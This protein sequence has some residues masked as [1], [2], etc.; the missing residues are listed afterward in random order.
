MVDPKFLGRYV[1]GI[2]CDGASYHSSKSARDRDILRQKV[3]EELG[4]TIYRIWSTDW[5]RDPAGQSRKLISFIQ[6][7]RERTCAPLIPRGRH[8]ESSMGLAT[9]RT[10]ISD[11][12]WV[13]VLRF[14]DQ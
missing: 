13:G 14:D 9:L 3:L 11:G 4:W 5:F 6:S 2:E 10:Q 8:F 7:V 1:L 12:H